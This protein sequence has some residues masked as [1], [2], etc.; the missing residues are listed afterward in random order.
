MS[1]HLAKKKAAVLGCGSVG[2]L[3]AWC[4]ASAGVGTILLADRDELRA[5]NLRRH[6]CGCGDLGRSKPSSV[7]A[8]L[9]KRFPFLKVATHRF[10]FLDEPDRLR[11]L[12]AESD[13]VMVAVDDEGPKHLID[14]IAWELGRPVVYAGVYGSGWGM[15]VILV[16]PARQTTCYGCC[17]RAL[18]RTGIKLRPPQRSTAYTEP[19]AEPGPRAWD[20]ANLT[21]IMPAAALTAQIAVA[22]AEDQPGL[23]SE[24]TFRGSSAWRLGFRAG[25][26]PGL[27]S[28]RLK[29]VDVQ[30]L[31]NCPL[32]GQ[33]AGERNGKAFE[34]LLEQSP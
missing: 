19:T 12:I 3:E 18:G 21:S 8:F 30:R 31:E 22:T 15:E 32:C 27:G 34:Q 6:I 5:D 7:G 1:S 23:L 26:I 13:V 20:E 17:A 14:S 25:R 2:S 33:N 11:K 29:P 16:D 9:E 4:L 28:W 10:D 24:L